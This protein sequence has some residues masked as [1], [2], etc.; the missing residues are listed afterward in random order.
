MLVPFLCFT[1]LAGCQRDAPGDGAFCGDGV[2]DP[3]EAC[4]DGNLIDGDGCSAECEIE[5]IGCP[6][7]MVPVP[8]DP[9][10]GVDRSFCID[11]YEASRTDATAQHPGIASDL[12]V[13]Q[14]GVVPWHTTPIGLEVVDLYQAACQAAGKRLCRLE[15]WVSVCTGPA[16]TEYVYGNAFD[17]EV[18]NCVDTWCDDYC[19]EHPEIP[20]CPTGEGCGYATYSFRIVPT[21][22]FSDCVSHHGAYD[23][24]GNL[25]E[26]VIAEDS[27]VG[28]EVRGGAFNCAGAKARLKC[29]FNATWMGLYAGFRCCR[30]PW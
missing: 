14:P 2:L 6:E 19:A 26:V 24:C 9:A 22:E 8:A 1:A 21:G 4:D 18:C 20:D 5:P 13:S 30:D 28:Y 11:R 16:R 10:L 29:S 7:D 23:V 17:P 15:E 25:W 12:A 3:G 27:L